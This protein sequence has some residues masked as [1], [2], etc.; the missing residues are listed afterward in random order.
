MV[1]CGGWDGLTT[2]SEC[3]SIQPARP[4]LGWQV[5]PPLPVKTSHAATAVLGEKMF[6]FGGEREERCEASPQ[7]QILSSRPRLS[8]SLSAATDPPRPLGGHNC[9]VSLASSATS[10]ILVIGGWTDPSCEG[11]QDSL[12]N[13]LDQVYIL[14]TNTAT[15]TQG[16]RLNTRRRDHGCTVVSV[17]G[18][19]VS[20]TE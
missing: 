20:W 12:T 9:A 19:T 2:S 3:Y 14:D 1:V 4:E 7:L 18:R 17:A 8:W 13:Y 5:S 15:W 6:V 11:R 16:P 10:L